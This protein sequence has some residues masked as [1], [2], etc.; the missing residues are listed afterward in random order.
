MQLEENADTHC[1]NACV[2][3]SDLHLNEAES[4]TDSAVDLAL[5]K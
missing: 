4:Q 5:Q 1:L 3:L 2:L